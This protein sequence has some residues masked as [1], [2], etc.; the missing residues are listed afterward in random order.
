MFVDAMVSPMPA[1]QQEPT[2]GDVVAR[3]LAGDREAYRILV[4]RYQ[5]LLYRHGLRMTASRDVA[6]DLMQAAFVKAYARLSH[7][8]DP[9]RFGAWLFRIH[10]NGCKDHLKS[11]RQRDVSLEEPAARPA[12]MDPGLDPAAAAENAELHRLLEGA[13]AGLTPPL[14]EAFLLKHAEGHS[15]EEMAEMLGVSIPALKMRVHRAREALRAVLEE[16]L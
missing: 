3:V 15:Y 1:V 9:D 4:G 2:D 11:R 13:L 12:A 10:A 14:R 16:V 8:R 6:E 7:C 5:D